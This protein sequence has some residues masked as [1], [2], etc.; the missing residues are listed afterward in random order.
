MTVEQQVL[1]RA[2]ARIGYYAPADPEP[3]SEAGRYVAAKLDQPWL[4]GPSATTWWC[5]L[6]VSMC[7]DECGQAEAIG[8][9]SWNTDTTLTR[10]RSGRG[11]SL[12]PVA[13]SRP[14]DV[15][16]FDWQGDG[17]TDHVGLVEAN[18]GGGW[19]RTIEGNTSSGSLGSQSAGNGVWR[20][21]RSEAIASVIRPSYNAA[22]TTTASPTASTASQ[23]ESMFT[24]VK[25]PRRPATLVA[26]GFVHVFRNS[27]ELECTLNVLRPVVRDTL[28][29]RQV[30]VI[31]AVIMG[32]TLDA[33]KTAS[34]LDKIL[35]QLDRKAGA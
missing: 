17:P 14:G 3:G 20:R 1:S 15:V 11:G 35:G 34:Q 21:V 22:S 33:D 13:A 16:I 25:S 32:G 18:L 19:L 31:K 6:F 8:G 7:L 12:V 4:A 5:M 10:V 30:D 27:E 2:A 28:N 29:D 24:V 26:P 9:M 23:E